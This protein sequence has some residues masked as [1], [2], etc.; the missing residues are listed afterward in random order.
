MYRTTDKTSAWFKPRLNW[1]KRIGIDLII[2]IPAG[3]S[4]LLE[5]GNG[6]L[7]WKNSLPGRRQILSCKSISS[8]DYNIN[9]IFFLISTSNFWNCNI[10]W[11]FCIIESVLKTCCSVKVKWHSSLFGWKD[12]FLFSVWMCCTRLNVCSC[13]F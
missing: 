4:Y 1:L 6:I 11:S 9:L 3:S 2:H 13:H 12:H 10:F 5:I 7:T 8:L